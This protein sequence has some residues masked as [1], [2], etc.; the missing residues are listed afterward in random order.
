MTNLF[1]NK[2]RLNKHQ[3]VF[4]LAV[5]MAILTL[6]MCLWFMVGKTSPLLL[7]LQVLWTSVLTI[8]TSRLCVAVPHNMHSG[9][10]MLYGISLGLCIGTLAFSN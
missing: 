10:L 3:T 8:T 1:K 2:V 4:V 9:A 7:Y 5:M 6:G